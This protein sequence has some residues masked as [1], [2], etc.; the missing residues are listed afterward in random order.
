MKKRGSYIIIFFIALISVVH[1]MAQSGQPDVVCMGTSKNYYVDATSGSSY[2]WKI[3]EGSPEASTTNSVNIN[4]TKSGIYTLTV[5]EIT[6]DSC[7]GPVQS[8][9]VTVIGLPTLQQTSEIGT[10]SQT[11]CWGG[12]IN[13]VTYSF[14]GG[15]TGVTVTGLPDGVN[16]VVNG[17]TVTLSG[18]PTMSGNYTITTV[19][20]AP[21]AEA[22]LKGSIT[23]NQLSTATIGGTTIACQNAA[24]P[25]VTFTGTGGSAPYTFTYN[26]NGTDTTVTTVT[27][28]SVT[29]SVPTTTPG[30]FR[31][32]LLGVKDSKACF[33]SQAGVVVVTVNPSTGSTTEVTTCPYALPYRWNGLSISSAGTYRVTLANS[34]GCD[35]IA[36]LIL[37]VKSPLT[38]TTKDYICSSLLPYVWNKKLCYE[39][40]TYTAQFINSSGCDSI[41]TLILTVVLP[42]SSITSEIVRSDE[43]P[44]VWNKM[45]LTENG[46]YTS[47]LDLI[48]SMGCDSIAKLILK[49]N[50]STSAFTNASVCSSDLPYIWNGSPYTASGV[51]T[52]KMT[53]ALGTDV[54]VTLNLTVIDAVKVSQAIHLFSGEKYTING[55][56]YDQ[57]GIYNDILK[58]VDG[59]DSTVVTNLT[60]IN[61]PNTLTPNGDGMNDVFMKGNHVQIYNRNGILLFEGTDGWDG[62]Y[63]GKLVSQDTYFYVLYYISGAKTKTK[64]GYLMVLRP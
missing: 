52:K 18:I 33:H 54:I 16:S 40:G 42:S 3:N 49:V 56:T 61:I 58:T 4:W 36:T 60:F 64:E 39:S 7:V 35:S 5:Q 43:L 12:A 28:N 24:S 32:R 63:H 6:K 21:C 22:S 13:K 62:T 41:A 38:S 55:H 53:N 27:G 50:L 30:A 14:G 48:N 44:Y 17:T 20:G 2:I 1:T 45:L 29:V 34:V 26:I 25:V 37:N 9:Q 15:A 59:C 57:E 51:Y 11:I 23:V 46:T 47:P 19:G 10:E 31:Y 8:L